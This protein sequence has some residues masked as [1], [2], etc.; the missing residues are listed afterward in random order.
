MEASSRK[1]EQLPVPMINEL[2][3]LNLAKRRET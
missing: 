3:A 1:P 2:H